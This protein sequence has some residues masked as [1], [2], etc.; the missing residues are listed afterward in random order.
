LNLPES[1][2]K[3]K[4]IGIVEMWNEEKLIT[5][6][7]KLPILLNQAQTKLFTIK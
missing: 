5:G 7:G 4:T 2:N 1:V 3:H 6:N